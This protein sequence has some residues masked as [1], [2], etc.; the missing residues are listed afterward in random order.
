MI[1]LVA[2]DL[3]GTLC[4]GDT[5]IETLAKSMGHIDRARELE[6]QHEQ[7]RDRD[8]LRVLREEIARCYGG[9]TETELNR[10]LSRLTLAPG[11]REGFAVLRAAGIETAI[12]TFTWEFAAAWLARELGASHWLGTRLRPDGGIDHVWPEDKAAW[13]ANLASRLR[14][15]RSEV[16]A[17]GDSWRD[18]PMF[19]AAGTSFYVGDVLPTGVRAIH[20]P[21]GDIADIARRIVSDRAVIVPF[22]RGHTGAVVEL[23]STVF[24]EYEMT[25]ELDG[26]DADLTDIETTYLRR[27]GVFFVLVSG[28][29]IIGTVGA[30]PHGDDESEIKRLYL[31]RDARG[32]GYGRR[33]LEQVLEWGR[34]RGDRRIVAWSDVRLETAHAVYDRMGFVRIGERITDDV[35]RSREYGFALSL[36]P[37]AS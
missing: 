12:V 30:V 31:R 24:A 2:F 3:D 19:Q 1:R 34:R 9:A 7:R 25:F 21:G 6:R 13:L 15:T 26:F 8:S 27:G 10:H 18:V 17:V 20:A 22:A 33:L 28:D 32:R 16:A 14:L 5:V 37:A 11:A 36:R 23:I 29:D 35:D 4:R